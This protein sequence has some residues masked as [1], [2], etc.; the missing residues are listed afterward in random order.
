MLRTPS[1]PGAYNALVPNDVKVMNPTR[2]EYFRGLLE[3]RKGMLRK[4]RKKMPKARVSPTCDAF[5]LAAGPRMD[6]LAQLLFLEKL[7]RDAAMDL[8]QIDAALRRLTA[9]TFGNC[10]VCGH[11]IDEGRLQ[12]LPHTPL[13]VACA[14]QAQSRFA[15]AASEPESPAR[16]LH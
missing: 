7:E 15:A 12:L 16:T 11:S 10:L 6:K 14:D 1:V 5:E 8:Q 9:G 2:K 13:C 4:R 3:S